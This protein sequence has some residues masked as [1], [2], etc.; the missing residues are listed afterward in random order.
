MRLSLL[1]IIS[2]PLLLSCKKD[3]SKRTEVYNQLTRAGWTFYLTSIV[4]SPGSTTHTSGLYHVPANVG[5]STLS[6][7]TMY[8]GNDFITFY[9]E[10]NDITYSWELENNL[11]DILV[12]KSAP[13]MNS[14][15]EIWAIK[16]LNDTL[17]DIRVRNVSDPEATENYWG[18]K[19]RRP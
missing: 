7:H 14:Y 11:S 16:Q 2:L 8:F 1:F 17:L 10:R 6:R 13:G 3:D 19:Y 5:A 15:R 12:N 18:F 9:P 4:S